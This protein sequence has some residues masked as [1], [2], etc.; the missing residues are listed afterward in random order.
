MRLYKVVWRY[1]QHYSPV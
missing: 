1:L